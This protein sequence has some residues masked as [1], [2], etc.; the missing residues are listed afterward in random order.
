MTDHLTALR[1]LRYAT[2]PTGP[3][4][5]YAVPGRAAGYGDESL[6]HPRETLWFLVGLVFSLLCYALMVLSLVY[7]P[8]LIV[9]GVVI[10][11]MHG[12][13]VGNI[14]GNAVKATEHQF[15]EVHHAAARLAQEMSL[16][17]MPEIYII[18]GNGLLNAFATR[19]A[20]RNFVILMADMV[21]LAY[22][23]GAPAL[24]FVICHELAHLK[25]GHSGWR[26]LL[27]MPAMLTPFLG[28][29]YSRA[30]E[31]TCDRFGARY[32]PEGASTGLLVLAAGKKLYRTVDVDRMLADAEREQGFWTWLSEVFSTH[33]HLTHRL[34]AV[35]RVADTRSLGALRAA[36]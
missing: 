8:L 36:H 30:C 7:V 22:E 6:V 13:M 20:G 4:L 19:F 27:L 28:K 9:A 10:F 29:A 26:R 11:V 24:E 34:R 25:R 35:K 15:S 23:Q 16:P 2:Q 14:R 33:P 1:S 18:Q 12:L 3:D 17:E 32:C 21:E 31:Y 5:G